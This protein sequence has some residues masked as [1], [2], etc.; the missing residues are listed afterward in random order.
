[1]I[2]CMENRETLPIVMVNGKH[3][4]SA[5]SDVIEMARLRRRC[6]QSA[7]KNGRGVEINGKSNS[8]KCAN[9]HQR[10]STP[11]PFQG[12]LEESRQRR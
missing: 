7:R 1:M 5:L 12:R 4:P 10:D 11:E 9:L 8:G 3:M 6:S 2:K